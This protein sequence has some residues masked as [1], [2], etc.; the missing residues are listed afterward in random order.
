M[1]NRITVLVLAIGL[2]LSASAS[3]DG[4]HVDSDHCGFDTNYDV[5]ATS[6]GIA[7][8]RADGRPANVFMHDGRLQ[9]DGHALNVSSVDAERLR[10]YEE[11]VR[12]LLPEMAGVAQEAMGIAFDSLT[13]V[14]ATLGGDASER[15]ALV[16]RLNQTHREAM[17]KLDAGISG[18]HWN[19]R[20][21]EQA[22]ETQVESAAD[23]LATSVSSGVLASLITGKSSELE[24]RANSL[25]ASIDK[26][27]KDRSG[28]LEARAKLLCPRMTELE[29][30]QQQFDFRLA[31]GSRLQLLT[32]EHHDAKHD[33]G[34]NQVAQH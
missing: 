24:A 4:I 1:R 25:D 19:E 29:S 10:S 27:M 6:H 21:F 7:F 22:I 31:D 33:D 8:T 11:N 20:G 30:L 23:E 17:V 28:K 2:A 16:R 26:E 34:D 13:T 12:T 3:A 14:A 15:D 18:D 32:R 9:V 5:Q